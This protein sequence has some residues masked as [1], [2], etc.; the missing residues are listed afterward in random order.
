MV[1]YKYYFTSYWERFVYV[2]QY[3]IALDS[4]IVEIYYFCVNK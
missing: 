1:V 3:F 2:L 4:F